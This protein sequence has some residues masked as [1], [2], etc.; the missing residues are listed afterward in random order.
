MT[1]GSMNDS[2]GCFLCG[3]R[4][5][6]AVFCSLCGSSLCSWECYIRHR[7]QHSVCQ[8]SKPDADEPQETGRVAIIRRDGWREEV[9]RP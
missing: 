1:Q 2:N 5:R 4:L 6:N 7:A 3:R 9:R 8:S